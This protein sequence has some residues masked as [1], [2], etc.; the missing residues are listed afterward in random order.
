MIDF[1]QKF[2]S[3]KFYFITKFYNL[4]IK[5]FKYNKND[6]IAILKKI[7]LLLIGYF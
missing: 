1:K 4:I 6:M 2:K 3:E 7:N 5:I